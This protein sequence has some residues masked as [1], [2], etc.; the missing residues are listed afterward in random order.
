ML[1]ILRLRG[2]HLRLIIALLI[3]AFFSISAHAEPNTL[4]Y[5]ASLYQSGHPLSGEFGTIREMTSWKQF[6]YVSWSDLDGDFWLDVWNLGQPTAPLFVT[7]YSFGNIFDDSNALVPAAHLKQPRDLKVLNNH[8]VLWSEFAVRA[9]PLYPDGTL[10]A[11][12]SSTL[13]GERN[14]NGIG[15]LT[16]AGQFAAAE[17]IMYSDA[18]VLDLLAGQYPLSVIEELLVQDGVVSLQDPTRPFFIAQSRANGE[19]VFTT[20]SPLNATFEGDPAILSV[21]RDQATLTVFRPTAPDHVRDFWLPKLTKLFKPG[22]FSRSLDDLTH[23]VVRQ[24]RVR[25]TQKLLFKQIGKKLRLSPK[26]RLA[27][28]ITRKFSN[29]TVL[30]SV[31]THY[32]ISAED[33]LDLAIERVIAHELREQLRVQLARRLYKELPRRWREQFL[34]IKNVTPAKLRRDLEEAF[35]GELSRLGIAHYL[36]HN[37]IGPLI[38]NPPAFDLTLGQLIDRI[39]DTPFAE[40]VDASLATFHAT[41]PISWIETALDFKAPGCFSVPRSA[42]TLLHLALIENGPKLDLSSPAL[43]ELL[44][45][46][47]FYDGNPHFGTYVRELEELIRRLHA[48][49]S[50]ELMRVVTGG[51]SITVDETVKLDALLRERGLVTNPGDALAAT[52]AQVITADLKRRGVDPSATVSATLEAQG[53]PLRFGG[54]TV[55]DLVRVLNRLRMGR[56]PALRFLERAGRGNSALLEAHLSAQ[57]Q[58]FTR[59]SFGDLSGSLTLEAALSRMALSKISPHL[60]GDSVQALLHTALDGVFTGRSFPGM[61]GAAIRAGQGDCFAQWELFLDAAALATA[62][63]FAFSFLS[64]LFVAADEALYWSMTNAVKYLANALL[65]EIADSVIGRYEQSYASWHVRLQPERYEVSLAGLVP[66][67]PTKI[68][69]FTHVD[70]IALLLRSVG[71]FGVD[72]GGSEEVF[73][74]TFDP[75]SPKATLKSR[76]L[77]RWEQIYRV[78]TVE[79]LLVIGGRIRGASPMSEVVLSVVDLADHE[80]AVSTIGD[81]DYW[82][83]AHVSGVALLPHSELLA[84]ATEEQQIALVQLRR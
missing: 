84:V 56:T 73:V 22:A 54:A 67:H 19:D 4:H 82:R 28:V 21:N 42:R 25:A 71:Q 45:L 41:Y 1:P 39:T 69:S 16:H 59:F 10:G 62:D 26:R 29:R 63:S 74:V 53:V 15:R 9:Y 18:E 37:V 70:R 20:E 58:A 78:A 57:V 47:Q 77:G 13:G 24:L 6:L 50:A 65:S 43:F 5:R 32:G 38:G 11:E 46:V 23:N 68:D 33:S 81:M 76:S 7:S 55:A 51:L 66:S 60:I 31:L 61:L 36:L 14:P 72:P 64:P 52:L 30:Y 40:V 34:A 27:K 17:R 44:K 3:S 80:L 49:A 2:V 83:L 75:R 12:H 8:L 35:H 79:G 48:A